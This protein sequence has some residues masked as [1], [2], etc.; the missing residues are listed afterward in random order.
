M[1]R[2]TVEKYA[3]PGFD[4]DDDMTIEFAIQLVEKDREVER[5]RGLLATSEMT[6]AEVIEANERLRA[7]ISEMA[8]CCAAHDANSFGCPCAEGA[9]EQNGDGK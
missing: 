2:A 1:D 6:V 5:L 7:K 8:T 4:S 3:P 9:N